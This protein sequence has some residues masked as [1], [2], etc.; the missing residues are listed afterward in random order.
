MNAPT[1]DIDIEI[2]TLG[3]SVIALMAEVKRLEKADKN[4]FSNYMFTSVDD[5]KDFIRPLMAKYNLFPSIDE[6][7]FKLKEI[8]TVDK[9]G[10]SKVGTVAIYNF[11]IVL[12]HAL[13]EKSEQE[14]RT[15]ALPFVGGQTSGIALS[16]ALKEWFK[17]KFLVSTGDQ[18]EEADL[19]DNTAEMRLGKQDGR[20]LYTELENEM[21][22][23]ILSS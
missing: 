5:H 2:Q 17:S 20:K 1:P 22:A 7:S 23:V 3:K 18:R 10:K 13:G 12:E 15:V 9:S 4:D 11:S 8:T 21:D 16:F 14:R 19:M 6:L